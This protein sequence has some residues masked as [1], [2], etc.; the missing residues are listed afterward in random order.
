MDVR[1]VLFLFTVVQHLTLCFGKREA[2]NEELAEFQ[3]VV[4]HI[5]YIPEESRAKKQWDSNDLTQKVS[6]VII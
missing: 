6:V 4:P 5:K 2:L 3:F 1:R